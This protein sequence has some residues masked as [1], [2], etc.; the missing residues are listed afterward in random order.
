M[1]EQPD[2]N[3]NA[4]SIPA[5]QQVTGV[6]RLLYLL[7][8]GFFLLLGVLGVAIPGLPTTPFLLL[9]SYFLVRTSPELN[10]KLLNSRLIGPVLTDWQ[11]K[12]GV[13]RSIKIKATSVV[14]LAVS[15]TIFFSEAGPGL[16]A[17]VICVAAIGIAVIIKLPTIPR[18][19]NSGSPQSSS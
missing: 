10:R 2:H 14:V 9:T 17:V 12:R 19:Q 18:N 13:R 8:A 6:R 1:D 3:F 7:A 16:C 11:V 15:A 4:H 5:V